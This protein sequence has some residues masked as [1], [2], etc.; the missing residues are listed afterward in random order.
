M[1]N[2]QADSENVIQISFRNEVPSNNIPNDIAHPASKRYPE[3]LSPEDDPLAQLLA[4]AD[5]EDEDYDCLEEENYIHAHAQPWAFQASYEDAP[6]EL[7]N[8]AL[9]QIKRLKEDAKRLKYYL[10]EMNID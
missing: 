8:N 3:T 2:S 4:E 1:K 10:D 7:G 6:R 9:R 5:I